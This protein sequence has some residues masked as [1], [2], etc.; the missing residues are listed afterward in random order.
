M[1]GGGRAAHPTLCHDDSI[2]PEGCKV[3]AL[4]PS[5]YDEAKT[6]TTAKGLPYLVAT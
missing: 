5:P 6:G 3:D 1:G 2:G 4:G